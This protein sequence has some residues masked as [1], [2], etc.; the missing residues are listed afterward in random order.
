LNAKL[1]ASQLELVV[2]NRRLVEA[3]AELEREKAKRIG[4][5]STSC[6]PKLRR[7]LAVKQNLLQ[8]NSMGNYQL[9]SSSSS[10]TY[11]RLPSN[12]SVWAYGEN[13]QLLLHEPSK[14]PMQVSTN[15]SN[16]PI[17]FTILS[18]C[19][20]YKAMIFISNAKPYFH[21]NF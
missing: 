17:F 4:L 9:Q 19:T 18:T 13:Q 1:E 10:Q 12:H 15:I 6:H 7:K 3:N 21:N 11:Q 5:G 2:I 14:P 8:Y 20:L 16:N